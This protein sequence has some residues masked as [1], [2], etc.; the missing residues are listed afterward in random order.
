VLTS[1][2]VALAIVAVCFA[3]FEALR[4]L[5]GGIFYY[6][7]QVSAYPEFAD[8]NGAPLGVAPPPGRLW[9]ATVVP[10][11]HK[12]LRATH[13]FDAELLLRY[14]ATQA[15]T[16][17]AVA[18]IG[19]AV[20]LPAFVTGGNRYLPPGAK[21]RTVGVE[22]LTLANVPARDAR[23]WAVLAGDVAIVAIILYVQ[24]R[25]I[26]HY[27]SVRREYRAAA[28]S[29]ANFAVLVLD[30]PPAARSDA[31][32]FRLFD[33][34]LVPEQ[35]AAV[36]PVRDAGRLL[37]LRNK[38]V[39]A[40]ARREAALAA[41]GEAAR[42]GTG[43]EGAKGAKGAEAAAVAEGAALAAV[44][45]ARADLD[46]SAPLTHAAFVTFRTRVATMVASNVPAAFNGMK[47]VR[48]P[49]PAAVYW[50]RIGVSRRT[51]SLRRYASF[52][53]VCA[54]TV[55][56][57]VPVGLV[58][59][60]SNFEALGEQK[61]LEFMADFRRSAPG[62]V[63][64]LEGFL[65]PV[66]LLVLNLLVPVF[67]RLILSRA[68]VYSLAQLDALVCRFMYIFYLT[69]TF[70]AN[71]VVGS[72]LSAIGSIVKDPDLVKLVAVL[73]NTIP[74]Q[75]SFF[76]NYTALQLGISAGVGILCIGKLLL[77][78]FFMAGA[79]TERQRRK[80]SDALSAYPFFKVY[81]IT[82]LHVLIATVYSAVAP[83]CAL[84]VAIG[85][86]VLYAAM[87]HVVMYSDRQ[88]YN[89]AGL[90]FKTAWEHNFFS[91][92]M[93]CVIMIG[94]FGLKKS[95]V[96]AALEVVLLGV[97]VYFFRHCK[98]TYYRVALHGATED[99]AVAGEDIP[100]HYSDKYVHPGLQD[101]GDIPALD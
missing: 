79:H 33:E 74:S 81:A 80:A 100:P 36:H 14:L 65:P 21:E 19:A 67:L 52:A 50:T 59:A 29:P 89:S 91:L 34:H 8:D 63:T 68:R 39:A 35:V 94:L 25:N 86:A 73:S 95:P 71:V 60:L 17:A 77:Q 76:L 66:L 97:S 54:M 44:V 26:V 69:T 43:A 98:R 75:S 41:A 16:F 64:L 87:K 46:A 47:V 55:V 45:D 22:L 85:L 93:H 10:Y 99:L 20:L 38:Y 70:I 72:L 61:G 30:L 37:A 62:F 57:F 58:Q 83:L 92:F 51:A 90:L 15:L 40:H 3:A 24:H 5:C 9:L 2:A 31:A 96:P 88:L 28:A 56:W 48:A 32:V 49:E 82:G 23:L 53:A 18:A 42:G 27:T 4:R 6:R 84:F 101:V 11:P 78:P 13:G 1:A 12:T 7:N